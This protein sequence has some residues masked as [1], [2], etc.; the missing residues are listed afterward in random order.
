VTALDS[1][2]AY[3][4]AIRR[5][6]EELAA[7]LGLSEMDVKLFRRFH[8]LREICV[9]P[10]TSLTDLLLNAAAGL[11]LRGREHRVRYVLWARAFPTVVPFPANPLH[12]VCRALGLGHALA[13]TLTQQSCA[14]AL[15]AID[16]AGRLLAADAIAGPV[17]DSTVGSVADSAVGESDT[18]PLALVFTGE[19]AFTRDAQ[20]LPG[21]SLFSE[22]ASACL[23]SATGSRDRLLAYA[24]SQRGEFDP[25]G[26]GSPERFQNEYRPL[27]AEVIS[28]ALE[29]AGLAL[30]DLALLLPHNVNLVTWQR[31]CRLIGFPPE[32]V[33]LDNIA[34]NGHVFCA[35]AFLNY[36]TARERGLLRTGDRYLVA[37]VGAGHGATFAAMVFQH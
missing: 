21:M 1:V 20:V 19:K 14:S 34:G 36:Q 9:D 15:Q 27:L 23:V 11:D 25:A 33:M 30:A 6:V 5:T 24:C 35:D 31:M 12:E 16:L 8:G 2:A 18:A 37:T 3:Q 32:R 22:G 29:Q 26:D 10:D 13:F 4:P 28:Q 7:P 17:A